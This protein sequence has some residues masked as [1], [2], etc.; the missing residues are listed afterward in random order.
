MKKAIAMLLGITFL[1]IMTACSSKQPDKQETDQA[2]STMTTQDSTTAETEGT[3]SEPTA[4]KPEASSEPAA[5]LPEQTKEEEPMKEVQFYITANGTTF[6]A[7]FA[8][9]DSADAFREM[10]REGDLTI[11]M[12]DYGSFEKVGSIKASLPRKDTQIS[13]TT[14]DVMLYQGDQIVIFYGTNSWSYS[15]LGKIN[16]ASA[17]E[18]LAAFGS[19]DVTVIFS[20]A[21]LK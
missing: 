18:M 17:E 10:L 15:R 11:H 21:K 8:D 2:T 12:S 4:G 3:T 20:L 9:N 19:G 16:G 6:P 5:E 14:G 1:F 13:T 7:N